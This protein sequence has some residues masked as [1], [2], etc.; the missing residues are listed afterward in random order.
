MNEEEKTELIDVYKK[1]T[2]AKFEE[3]LLAGKDEYREGV[4]ELLL[5]EES[6]RG[7]EVSKI[8]LDKQILPKILPNWV[9]TIVIL[10]IAVSIF[11]IFISGGDVLIK[12]IYAPIYTVTVYSVYKK[13]VEKKNW[14]R[15]VLS[16]LTC[17]IGLFILNSGDVKLY[18][19]QKNEKNVP[20]LNKI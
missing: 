15:I 17:P 8:E 4:Y 19:M 1:M 13:L 2:D 12:V 14:A 5:N 11:S 3:M 9:K 16:I 10:A 6:R 20:K 7:M 18:V